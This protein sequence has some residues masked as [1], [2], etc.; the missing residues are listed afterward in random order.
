MLDDYVLLDLETTGATPLRDRI[1][2]IALIRFRDGV[3][4][5][6]WQTLVNPQ[7]NIPDFIQSLT[8]ITNEMVEDAPVFEKVAGELLDYL[9]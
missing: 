7:T 6:R 4:I 3:E 5:D 9:E 1:T 2:E 8:G